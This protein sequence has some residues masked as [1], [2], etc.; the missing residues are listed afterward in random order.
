MTPGNPEQPETWGIL[1][2]EEHERHPDQDV[3]VLRVGRTAGDSYGSW[4][5]VSSRDVPGGQDYRM[6]G[7]PETVAR[8]ATHY[9]G[10][11]QSLRWNPDLVCFRGYVRRR[12]S[13]PLP[14]SNYE[15][16]AFYELSE[17]AGA[18]CS[19]SPVYVPRVTQG[20][21]VIGMYVGEITSNHRA[22]YAVR[23]ECIANWE[24]KLLGH[25]IA[26]ECA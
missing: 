8:E 19:G 4:A 10:I 14:T 5:H 26:Q 1:R 21:D 13:R 9:E 17:V 2:I 12:I 15:G 22:G 3:S 23:S 16:N 11:G 6:V 7:Y 20:W 18:C 24:P 25:S